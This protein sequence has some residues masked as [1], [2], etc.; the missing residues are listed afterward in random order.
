[1]P[2]GAD[3]VVDVVGQ[4]DCLCGR[5]NDVFRR[6]AKGA[7]P[8]SIPNPH[9]LA[10]AVWNARTD[11]VNIAC[12]VA[13]RND[14]R[15]HQ[16][17]SETAAAHLPVRRIDSG[18][19]KPDP[20]LPR[21]RLWRRLMT[22]P[23]HVARRTLF[24]IESCMHEILP[25]SHRSAA[26]NSRLVI[27]HSASTC[28][29]GQGGHC[30]VQRSLGSGQVLPMRLKPIKVRPD[31]GMFNSPTGVFRHCLTY[32]SRGWRLVSDGIPRQTSQPMDWRASPRSGHPRRPAA[33][34]RFSSAYPAR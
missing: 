31:T 18:G 30:P 22:D 1:M 11:G 4:M 7:L 20:D 17:T 19:S 2:T 10:N 3:G 16:G 26:T 25:R 9:A 8:L 28:Y 24:R 23:Q 12:A 5:Q 29:T 21:T 13:V 32:L 34:R 27:G 33:A 6:S 15:R 14:Q